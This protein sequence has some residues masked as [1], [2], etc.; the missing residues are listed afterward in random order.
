MGHTFQPWFPDGSGQK[1][2][3]GWLCASENEDGDPSPFTDEA[4]HRLADLA[5][6]S[7]REKGDTGTS[8][9]LIG[10]H[11]AKT[12]LRI[13]N[14]RRALETWWWPALLDNQ[15]D[16]E[17]WE[18]NKKVPGP[19]PRLREDLKPFIACKA[20]LDTGVGDEVSESAFH[21]EHG[22]GLGRLALTL[23]ADESI[24]DSPLHPKYPGPRR[25]ARM[26]VAA[27][28]ITEYKDF[29]TARR[30]SFTG[31]YS[32]SDDVDDALKFSE[33]ATHDEWSPVSQRLARAK[34]GADL[35]KAIE[36][37][38]N[39][40]C[41]AF[42]RK[43]SAARAPITDRLPALERLLG[44]AFD[45]RDDVG[46]KKK[47]RKKPSYHRATVVD[48]PGSA[49][50]K[51]TPAFG[52]ATNKLDFLIRYNLRPE[53]TKKAKVV[54]WLDVS[55]VLDAE[56]KKGDPLMLEVVDQATRH[57]VYRGA[58]PRYNVEVAPGKSKT[59]RVSSA[60]YPRH[61]VVMFDEGEVATKRAP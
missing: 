43:N 2:G 18:N 29:G 54:A 53:I 59:F 24:F 16:V 23:A 17:L 31:F 14:I 41:L 1:T 57:V 28:M 61:Q 45:E 42:Q 13:D 39:A 35:V 50:G 9:L 37:R 8:F 30:L 56:H 21:R 34:H 55:V 51:I 22:K 12:P 38:T 60:P 5:G 52:K 25:V 27:G 26:R 10:T 7:S 32:G 6:F 44:S 47:K 36:D 49:D 58:D 33:P 19:A 40:A 15:L 11:P 46:G 3:R 4:A 48:F 20:R